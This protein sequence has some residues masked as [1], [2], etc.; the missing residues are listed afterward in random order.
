[1]RGPTT[2]VSQPSVSQSAHAVQ[3]VGARGPGGANFLVS[4]PRALS[5]RRWLPDAMDA[6]SVETDAETVGRCYHREIIAN[7]RTKAPRRRIMRAVRSRDTGPERG[8]R[9]LLHDLGYRY[10]LHRRDL[11]GSP[12]LAFSAR[13]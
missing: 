12:D 11:P 4:I 6:L 7:T 5:P 9:R 1:M 2:R 13:A 8:V 10:R 3:R